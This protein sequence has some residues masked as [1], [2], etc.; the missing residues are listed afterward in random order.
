MRLH[1]LL[2]LTACLIGMTSMALAE[3]P[4]PLSKGEKDKT[5]QQLQ[6]TA[7]QSLEYYADK[8][9]Y[10]AR[11]DAKAI[12]GTLTVTADILTAHEREKQPGAAKQPKTAK[13]DKS[14]AGDI[15]LMTAEGHVVIVDPRQRI[16][17]EH[18][19]YDLDKHK[20]IV[21][22]NNLRYETAKEVVTAT[23]SLEYY[24]DTKLA[25]AR[26]HAIADQ[27]TRHIEGDLLT[28]EFRDAPNGQSQLTKMTSQGH[29]TVITKSTESTETKEATPAK[30]GKPKS[31]NTKGGD[32]SRGDRA[33]YDAGS[34]MAI[35]TGDVRITRKDGTELSGDVGEV[36]F[37]NNQNRLMNNGTGRVKA[38]LPEK[39]TNKATGAK[40]AP[41]PEIAAP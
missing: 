39:T 36:D 26:G 25:V 9:L 24:E 16:T 6:V 41:E 3:P 30:D 38:L 8:R 13:D 14:G 15:D 34:N 2:G 20:M 40:T 18:A 27:P 11:G 7:G 37:N 21:T 1:T 31:E 29:V 22:G 10:V 17:G 28:A 12:R 4:S 33:V 5:P 19:V 23:D 32:V 35:L